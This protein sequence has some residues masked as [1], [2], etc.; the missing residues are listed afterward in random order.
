MPRVEIHALQ[1][2]N[3]T[4]HSWQ[5]M[6]E[7][8]AQFAKAPIAAI[9]RLNTNQLE[10]YCVNHDATNP[11]RVGT[12]FPL[13]SNNFCESV[14]KTDRILDLNDALNQSQWSTF[15]PVTHF[16]IKAYLGIP[17]HWP[18]GSPFGTLTLQDTQPNKFK[19]QVLELLE[20]FKDSVE[21]QL[22]VIY[23]NKKL[24]RNN[25]T[26]TS[27]IHNRTI[28]L[29]SLS[30]QLDKE[31]SRCKQLEREVHYQRYH[32]I[33]SGLLNAKAWELE[34]NRLVNQ[35]DLY[36][37]E[38]A[39][40][41]IGISNGARIQAELGARA[42]DL[43]FKQLTDK[44]GR[45]SNGTQITAR[46]HSSDIAYTLVNPIAQE[47]YDSSIQ[48]I[49]D[50]TAQQFHVADNHVRLQAYIGVSVSNSLAGQRNL[51]LTVQARQAMQHAQ[52]SGK[53]ILF[54][55]ETQNDGGTRFNRMESYFIESIQDHTLSLH[56]QPQVCVH[57]AVWQCATTSIYWSH[58]ILGMISELSI[59]QLCDQPELADSLCHYLVHHSLKT[60]VKWRKY[61]KD[62]R[63]AIKLTASQLASN[64]L[65][66]LLQQQLQHFKLPPDAIE[67]EIS[68]KQLVSNQAALSTSLDAIAKLGIILTLSDF[69]HGHASFS[70]LKH[71]PFKRIKIDKNFTYNLQGSAEDK[72]FLHSLM[73]IIEKLELQPVVTGIKTKEQERWLTQFKRP[74][75]EGE[76]YQIPLNAHEFEQALSKQTLCLQTY[77]AIR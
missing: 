53:R 41:Y 52:Q 46:P 60:A 22:T 74:F 62:F 39:V 68:E 19:P 76:I 40:F 49:L 32:D 37:H 10:V 25:E 38:V 26:L 66:E 1:I 15:D 28:E 36:T 71:S 20:V 14:L 35:T 5:D 57:S 27:R 18:N 65:A 30:Y 7:V 12:T 3:K 64:T 42:L 43:I 70:Y 24:Q 2:P 4:Y 67:I 29:A 47:Q 17:I 23:Q 56:Y 31:S 44:L 8:F 11:Y 51:G 59:V 21:A 55:D 58:P 33:G 69:G 61:N 73:Q 9:N 54:F 48:R 6:L 34:S 72:A 13:N 50:I 16:G 75:A 45:L 63:I 77:S